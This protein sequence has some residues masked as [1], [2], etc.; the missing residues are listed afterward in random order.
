MIQIWLMVFQMGWN[1]QLE[2]LCYCP[3]L[4]VGNSAGKRLVDVEELGGKKGGWSAQVL[5]FVK[6]TSGSDYEWVHWNLT[7]R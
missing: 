7:H 2:S 5:Q 1:H 4:V 6:K 3:W